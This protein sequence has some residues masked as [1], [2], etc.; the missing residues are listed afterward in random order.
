[1]K[2]QQHEGFWKPTMNVSSLEFG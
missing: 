1:L 2:Q